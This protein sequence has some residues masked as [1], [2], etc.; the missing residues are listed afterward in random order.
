QF[1]PVDLRTARNL[2]LKWDQCGSGLAHEEVDVVPDLA[3]SRASPL[4]QGIVSPVVLDL[5]QGNTQL[6]ARLSGDTHLLL[7]IGAP[8]LD[9]VLR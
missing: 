2:A 4:P 1:L 6:V 5:G 7:E 9:L 3:P 8:E